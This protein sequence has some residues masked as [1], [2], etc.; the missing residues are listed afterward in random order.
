MGL[1]NKVTEDGFVTELGATD[2]QL[3]LSVSDSVT[4]ATVG[5]VDLPVG[6]VVLRVDSANNAH[7]V[8]LAANHVVLGNTVVVVNVDSAQSC[9]LQPPSGGTILGGNETLAAG[10]A[11]KVV[12]V[13][14]TSGAS[15]WA[16]I[17]S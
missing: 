12:C 2:A 7:I 1:R 17:S 10:A 13:D 9:V 3:V 4:T 16:K 6:P 11:V 14:A 8:K 5:G 15:V